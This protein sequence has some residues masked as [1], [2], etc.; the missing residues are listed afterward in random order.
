[1]FRD[2]YRRLGSTVVRLARAREGNTAM[3]FGLLLV[4]LVV[5]AGGAADYI[6]LQ[7]VRSK[8]NAAADAAVLGAAN[9]DAMELSTADATTL[10]GKLF[11]AQL[12]VRIAGFVTTKTPTVT[13][14]GSDRTTDFVYTA[15][16]PTTF[17][18]LIGI[19]TVSLS[20][21]A[22]AAATLPTYID[23][24]LLLDNT[25]SMGVAATPAGISTM[26]ANTGD[27]CAFACHDMSTTPNDYYGLAKKLGVAMRIDVVRTA[28]QQLM[29]TAKST[30]AVA[31]QFR[32][33]IYTFGAS[34]TARKLTTIS[35]LTNNLSAAKTAANAVDL[36]T[37]PYH[38]YNQDRDTDFDGILK[39]I[40][41]VIPNPGPGNSASAVPQKFLFFVSDG[42]ADAD[43]SSTCTEAD[44]GGPR[45]QEPLT[46]AQ[47]TAIK[48]RGIKI[49]VLYTT[50]LPLPTNWWYQTT[51]APW[52]SKIAT[53]MEA[54]ASPGYYF[55]V[56]PT[57]GISEAMN[58]LFRK[59]VQGARLTN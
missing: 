43:Y 25:P 33:A 48:K 58:A 55:E 29:D 17:L 42:V 16:V 19:P 39:S 37:V 1:M 23:F 21:K 24:Y 10:A 8:L 27:Q 46:V 32:M 44:L 7:E 18:P 41:K 11:D 31:K 4:P 2:W 14:S 59:A 34:A 6:Y 9:K 47:C 12:P 35:S 49:A 26:V 53:N 56:S 36:M 52:S 30:Q 22:T 20:G 50:Y 54:C 57:D 5:A 28:T 38:N 45:C 13:D 15:K 51:I 3:M 40:N